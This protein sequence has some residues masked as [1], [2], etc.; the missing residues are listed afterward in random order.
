MV[1]SGIRGV[2]SERILSTEGKGRRANQDS[3]IGF[4]PDLEFGAARAE[5][6]WAY[7]RGFNPLFDDVFRGDGTFFCQEISKGEISGPV[8]FWVG[9]RDAFLKIIGI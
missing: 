9:L 5:A 2:R 6:F 3:T 7:F 1:V 8:R 4:T